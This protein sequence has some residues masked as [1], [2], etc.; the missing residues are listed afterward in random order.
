[1]LRFDGRHIGR[2]ETL[3]ALA[4]AGT[5]A[6]SSAASAQTSG[7]FTWDPLA[8]PVEGGGAMP[9][10]GGIGGGFSSPKYRFIDLDRDGDL[11]FTSLDPD[12]RIAV[13]RNAGSATDPRYEPQSDNIVEPPIVAAEPWFAFADI[14]A[15]SVL[16]LFGGVAPDG[17]PIGYY[18]NVGTPAEPRFLWQPNATF[19]DSAQVSP[20]DGNTPAFVDLDADGDLD[21]CFMNTGL[22]TAVVNWNLGT[23]TQPFY[24]SQRF[25]FGGI[26]TFVQGLSAGRSAPAARGPQAEAEPRHGPA[27]PTFSDVDGDADYDLFIGD[28]N[29]SNLW[30]FRN[31]GTPDSAA[32]TKVTDTLLPFPVAGGS[33]FQVWNDV[34]D[35]DGDGG[36]ELIA[37]P[38]DVLGLLDRSLLVFRDQGAAGT[39]EFVYVDDEPI[40]GLDLGAITRPVLADIDADSD[41]DLVVGR[42]TSQDLDGDGVPGLRL[43]ENIGT[44]AAPAFRPVPPQEDPFAAVTHPQLATPAPALADMDGDGDLDLLAGQQ[45]EDYQVFYFE[46]QGTASSANFQFTGFL[47]DAVLPGNRRHRPDDVGAPTVGDLDRDGDLDLLVGEFGVSGRPKIYWYD[48]LGEFDLTA[49]G[50]QPRLAWVTSRADSAFGFNTFADTV[51]QHLVPLLV[52]S[53]CDGYLDIW[54]GSV[55]GR[56]REYRNRGAGDSLRFD[57]ATNAFEGIDVGRLSTPAFGDIDADG[58]L[59][60]FVGEENGGINFYRNNSGGL[61]VTANDEGIAVEWRAAVSG[62]DAIRIER[63]EGAGEF[64]IIA[65]VSQSAGPLFAFQDSTAGFAGNSYRYALD[66]SEID[67]ACASYGPVEIAVGFPSIVLES[68]SVSFGVGGATVRWGVSATYRGLSFRLTRSAG[69][70]AFMPVA[71]AEALAGMLENVFVDPSGLAGAMYRV[72]ALYMKDGAPT[73]APDSVFAPAVLDAA[74]DFRIYTARPNPSRGPVQIL[75]DLPEDASV[76]LRVF[77]ASG[78]RIREV[79]PTLVPLG[80]QRSF[81]WDGRDDD[82]EEVTGGIYFYSITAGSRVAQGRIVRLR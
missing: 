32:Y 14:D 28:L 66:A 41:L 46:N 65:E 26:N 58:D 12:G 81:V 42:F 78:R 11:D 20:G 59:D 45:G 73:A 52:D 50:R 75:M 76:T 16:D 72:E 82:G 19:L 31:D 15:D 44:A 24:S 77:D 64:A 79:G 37:S 57:R 17:N 70:G 61:T 54:V 47:L 27:I 30:F 5:L 48:N 62:S 25:E 38:R 7:A 29:N 1:M 10:Y 71:G 56:L 60:L 40:S 21:F 8:F 74:I 36:L 80:A 18:K 9:F 69:G 43:F 67:L 34:V 39:L 53:N 6:A 3:F 13:Y 23:R 22:G 55:D 49:G 35:L 68:S 51:T 63:A 4:L 2:R 33:F